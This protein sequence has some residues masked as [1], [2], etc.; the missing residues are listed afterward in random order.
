MP[1]TRKWQ[2]YQAISGRLVRT[3]ADFVCRTRFGAIMQCDPSDFIQNKVL[4]FG[5]WEP[6]VTA[7]ITALA[8]PGAVV[9]DIGANVGY[10]TLLLSKLVGRDGL[11]VAIEPNPAA[12]RRLVRNLALNDAANVRVVD[13]AVTAEI[14]TLPIFG[15]IEGNLGSVSIVAER[16]VEQVAEVATGPLAE[17]LTADEMARTSFIKI[18]VEGA[19]AEVLEQILAGLASF[20]ALKHVLVEMSNADGADFF[21]RFVTAGFRAAIVPNSYSLDAYWGR[22]ARQAPAPIDRLPEEQVDMLFSRD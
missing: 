3:S 20:P 11:V 8:A 19:E 1:A 21:A 4:L 9:V 22:P 13:R 18:D 16:G 5:V 6:G 7:A 12:L 17:L 15:V 10:D 2:A 14:G